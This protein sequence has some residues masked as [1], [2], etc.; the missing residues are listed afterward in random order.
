MANTPTPN[1]FLLEPALNDLGWNTPLNANFTAIDQALGSSFPIYVGTGG[2]IA[3]TSSTPN[4]NGIYW[5]TAQ[6]LTIS[7]GT[8]ITPA[9]LNSNAVITLPASIDSAGNMGGAWIIT[10]LLTG[11]QQGTY[12][13]T[14]QGASGSGILIAPGRTAFVFFDGVNVYNTN[15]NQTLYGGFTITGAAT[16]LS[17]IFYSQINFAGSGS[18][19]VTLPDPSLYN[20]A[21]FNIYLS[22]TAGTITLSTPSG[23]FGGYSGG[24]ASTLNITQSTTG[25]YYWLRSDGT[26]WTVFISPF[27]TSTGAINNLIYKNNPV[28]VTTNAGT[29]PVTFRLNTFTNSSA[30]NMTITMALTG[31]VDG[32]MTIVRIYDASAVAKTITW[33]NT[34][35]STVSAPT[36]SNGSTTLPLTVG[37]MYNAATSK[38]RCIASA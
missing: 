35:N 9:N 16:L 22:N 32:Q 31:A 25:P 38:W 3:L 24:G 11:T 2:T 15:T 1:K 6:Q 13:V 17:S 19:T 29:V 8:N 10:N 26:N 30:A 23:T 36:T 4:V 34:E 20:G 14:V 18:Y 33:V 28:T 21:W 12:T 27:L 5:Y 37:F 7:P